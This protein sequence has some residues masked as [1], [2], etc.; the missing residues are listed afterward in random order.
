MR[1]MADIEPKAKRLPKGVRQGKD[2]RFYWEIDRLREDGT[3]FRKQGNS[4]TAADASTN[5]KAAIQAFEAGEAQQTQTMTLGEWADYCL[6]SIFPVAPSRRGKAFAATT[7]EGYSQAIQFHIKPL[8][9]SILLTKLTPEH[10][11]SALARIDGTQTK[12]KVRSVGSKL[13]ELAIMRRKVTSN[14][15]K[16]VQIAKPRKERHS[17]GQ[18]MEQV[19]ILTTAEEECL[20][21]K[22]QEH[23]A[24]GWVYGGI[25]LGLRLGLRAGEILGLEWRNVDLEGGTVTISQQRQRVTKATRDRMGIKSKGGVLVVDPKTDAGFRRIPVPPS[26]LAWLKEERAR[27]ET[28]YLF[29]NEHG[30]NARE[31]RRFAAGFEAMVKACGL[32]ES[33]DAHGMPLPEPTPHDLRHTFCSRM[34]NVHK[35]PVQVLAV[36]AG[37]SDIKTTLTYYVH[38]DTAGIVEAMAHVP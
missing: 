37:H 21:K 13:Y 12:I 30:T 32:H 9:G 14:P 25:L 26:V 10:I 34:A 24:Y 38:A 1:S 4:K 5:R 29:P 33:K 11:D 28:Q 23:K 2:G 27:N 3:R 16:V 6:E 8:L 20:L 31:P 36:I 15:F 22:A 19:R 18:T 17:N 35:V 7:V